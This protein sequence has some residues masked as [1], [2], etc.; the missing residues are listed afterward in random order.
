MKIK[1][2]DGQL[3]F[4]DKIEILGCLCMNVK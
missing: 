1:Q 2:G 3:D 4:Q